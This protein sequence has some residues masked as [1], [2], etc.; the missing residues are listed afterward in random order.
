MPRNGHRRKLAAAREDFED[1][2]VYDLNLASGQQGN[3]GGKTQNGTYSYIAR[4]NYDYNEKYLL[5]LMG[6]RDGNSKFAKGHKF[7][8]FGSMSLGMG[9]YKRKV[10]GIPLSGDEFW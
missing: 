9:L 10:Y 7:Q 5:E 1:S 4:V 2:G 8:N 6:R 3:S